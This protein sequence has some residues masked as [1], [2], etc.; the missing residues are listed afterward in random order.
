MA[1]FSFY[2]GVPR[3]NDFIF[4]LPFYA[5][6]VTITKC[7]SVTNLSWLSTL[8]PGKAK[9]YLNS[10]CITSFQILQ[11]WTIGFILSAETL[12]D[13]YKTSLVHPYYV[14][15]VLLFY[16]DQYD[17]HQ[18]FK[19]VV[20]GNCCAAVFVVSIF[21][22]WSHLCDSVSHSDGSFFLLCSVSVW[23]PV[24]APVYPIVMGRSSCCVL[25][26]YEFPSVRQCI[27]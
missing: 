13:I 25:C 27:P 24:C 10:A 2:T 1:K 9:Y 22:T 3:T 12:E 4:N 23:V 21:S 15:H 16:F 11:C 6:V 8:S 5:T 7:C 18:E 20:N 17:H 14:Q 19:T 26:L